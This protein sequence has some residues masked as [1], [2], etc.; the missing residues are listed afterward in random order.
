[1]IEI[2]DNNKIDFKYEVLYDDLRNHYIGEFLVSRD[3]K[4]FMNSI[5]AYKVWNEVYEEMKATRGYFSAGIDHAPQDATKTLIR[6]FNAINKQKTIENLV[7][8]IIEQFIKFKKQKTDFSDII[9]SASIADFS[10]ENL[11]IIRQAIKEHELKEFPEVTK[12]PERVPKEKSKEK[13]EKETKRNDKIFI[14]HGHNEEIKLNVARAI[15]KLK[16]TPIILHEQSNE[17]LT[18][19]EKFEKYSDVSFAI[20][21]LTFDDYGLSKSSTE[22]NKRARQNVVLELGYFLAKLGRKNVM[23]FYEEG[24]E[25]P[26]DISG[27]L[28]TIFDESENWKLRLVKELKVAGF[29]VDANDIL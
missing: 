29:K 24:V 13:E 17:G 10:E 5:G 26:S 1:M 25:L 21:L 8:E 16:L 4:L 7:T 28:Y 27:V 18:I 6:Y 23:P 2:F 15:E 14:V 11:E 12:T 9:E 3:F 22:K 20:I 19:I